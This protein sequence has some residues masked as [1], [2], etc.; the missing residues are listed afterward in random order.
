MR[1]VIAYDY[2]SGGGGGGGGG[3]GG[4]GLIGWFVVWWRT[5]LRLTQD[6]K[7]DGGLLGQRRTG[8]T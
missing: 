5:A 7:D 2:D 4:G 1:L 3:N 6:G 8:H